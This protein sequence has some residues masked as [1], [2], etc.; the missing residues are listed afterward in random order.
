VI[1]FPPPPVH[2]NPRLIHHRR[3]QVIGTPD[4]ERAFEAS[5]LLL[6][7]G[8]EKSLARFSADHGV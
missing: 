1:V 4:P 8:L 2:A 7:F 5:D 3:H 6:L